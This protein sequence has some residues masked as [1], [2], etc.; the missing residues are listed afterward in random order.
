MELPKKKNGVGEAKEG[1][2]E[3]TLWGASYIQK[4][5]K[6]IDIPTWID[7]DDEESVRFFV[8]RLNLMRVTVGS[9][10]AKGFM[11]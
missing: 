1:L 3:D 2:D 10:T 11:L 6:K 7:D 5:L 4:E 8:I 9:G